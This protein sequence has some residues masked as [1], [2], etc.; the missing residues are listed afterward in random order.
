MYAGRYCKKC[1]KGCNTETPISGFENEKQK[2]IKRYGSL[3]CNNCFIELIG[4]EEKVKE[5]TQQRIL[6]EM[7][8]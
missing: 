8:L 6:K 3:P 7:G 4:G 5:L 1:K 2:Q